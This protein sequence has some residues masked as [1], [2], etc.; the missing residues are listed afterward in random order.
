[1]D[2]DDVA[3]DD[4]DNDSDEDDKALLVKKF[5]LKGSPNRF[6]PVSSS[7]HQIQVSSSNGDDDSSNND[8]NDKVAHILINN[9]NTHPRTPPTAASFQQEKPNIPYAVI[10]EPESDLQFHQSRPMTLSDKVHY[11]LIRPPAPHLAGQKV[12]GS[13]GGSYTYHHG[14]PN[15]H[16]VGYIIKKKSPLEIEYSVQSG[17]AS[18]DMHMES[19]PEQ[20][21]YF[22]LKR[23]KSNDDKT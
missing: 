3:L 17:R 8:D 18:P 9:Y 6:F 12:V 21:P 4:D 23:K 1:M 22:P 19:E 11:D 20:S 2:E 15:K 5:G 14:D 13:N 7:S 10:K 16:L